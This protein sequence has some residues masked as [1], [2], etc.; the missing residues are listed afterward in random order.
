VSGVPTALVTGANRGLGLETCRQLARRGYVVILT[1]RDEALGRAAAGDL[2]AE[3]LNVDYRTLDVTSAGDISALAG[4]LEAQDQRLDVLV[5]NAGVSL[6]GFDADVVRRTLAVNFF[7]AMQVTDGL[8]DLVPDGGAIVFV[9]SGMGELSAYA[10]TIRA[11]FADEAITR[12]KLI[13]LVDEFATAVAAGRHQREGWPS[14]A[15]R[16]SKAAINALTRVLAR[17]LRPRRIRVNAA[18]PGWVRTRM[19]GPSASRSLEKGAESIVWAATLTDST[20]GGLFRDGRAI[21]W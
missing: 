18:C 11:R 16:V 10:P 20:S 4:G 3:G 6:N 14:S 12:E 9:S 19:G 7:G 2:A 1:S 21:A 13:A 15:Y 17:E 5:N 8:A